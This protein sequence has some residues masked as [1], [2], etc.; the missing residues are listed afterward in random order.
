MP[1]SL[2]GSVRPVASVSAAVVRDSQILM[3]RRRN[4]P[5]AGRWTLPGGKVEPGESLQEAV[6]RELREETGV[7]GV[8]RNVVTA[9]D[10]ISHDHHGRLIS[11]YVVVVVRTLWQGGAEAA[12]DD[13][14]EL[15]WM[16]LARLDAA[17]SEV[18]VTAAEVARRVLQDH[19]REETSLRQG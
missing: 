15:C 4:P 3:V 6:V 18:S 13:A 7:I 16:D 12:A 2:P 19:A 14:T 10:V 9:I 8:P 1:P 11:H 5:N 17:G